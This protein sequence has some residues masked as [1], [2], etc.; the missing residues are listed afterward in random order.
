MTM[1]TGD[2]QVRATPGVQR[3]GVKGRGAADLLATLG[4][5][6]PPRANQV[7]RAAGPPAGRCL[8]LGSTEFLVEQDAGDA[9][10]AALDAAVLTA[11]ANVLG[12]LRRD[13]CFLLSGTGLAEA[14][15]QIAAFDFEGPA[16][17][18][19][20]VVMTL[21]AGI[22]V[23]FIREPAL[24]TDALRLWCD[25]GFGDYLHDCFVALGGQSDT[26]SSSPHREPQGPPP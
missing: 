26:P 11:P 25:A 10:P 6:V 2:F 16:F 7:L 24:G 22:S 14:L 12:A 19:D 17:G 18:P 20:D 3:T 9:V 1:T 5:A 4:I 13:R 15:R 21:M 8:R 23:C